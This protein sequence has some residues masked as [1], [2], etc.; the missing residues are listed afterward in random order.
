MLADFLQDNAFFGARQLVFSSASSKTAYGTAFCLEAFAQVRRIALTSARNKRFVEALGCYGEVASYEELPKQDRGTP[1]L[2]VDFSGDEGL[3]MGLGKDLAKALGQHSCVLMRGHGSTV[4]APSLER[5]VYRA[6][7]T[8]ENAKLQLSAS[9]LGPIEFLT[10]EEAEKAMNTNE[11]QV[12]RPW[13]LWS[14][15]VGAVE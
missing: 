7:Y 15:A 4:V 1:T 3:R 13:E 14:R 12:M 6:V 9:A 2:Y 11:G 8:E 10:P 5:A